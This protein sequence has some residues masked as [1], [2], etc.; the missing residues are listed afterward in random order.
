ML[1]QPYPGNFSNLSTVETNKNNRRNFSVSVASNVSASNAPV[2]T[3]RLSTKEV[4]EEQSLE[5]QASVRGN[6]EPK[7]TWYL[8]GKVFKPSKGDSITQEGPRHK[9]FIKSISKDHAGQISIIAENE[10]GKATSSAEI[11]VTGNVNKRKGALKLMQE[12]FHKN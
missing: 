4:E 2:F 11:I 7:V 12:K 6:S 10:R 8:N 5:L 3:E 1:I 9:F